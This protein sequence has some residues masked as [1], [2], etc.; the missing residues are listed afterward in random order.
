M[1]LLTS[2][3]ISVA[4]SS[5]VVCTFTFLLF[6]SGYT[7]QQ[8]T[9][10]SLQAALQTPVEDRIRIRPTKTPQYT[11]PE[12]DIA[13]VLTSFDIERDGSDSTEIILN[14]VNDQNDN[15]DETEDDLGL[16]FD[17]RLAYVLS[18]PEP[19]ALCSALLFAKHYR[20]L[21][22]LPSSQVSIIYLYPSEWETST[23]PTHIQTLRLLL[24][25]E[26]EYSVLLH[27]VPISR[28]WTGIDTESQLLSELARSAWPYDRVLYL[29]TPGLL[30][31]TARLDDALLTSYTVPSTLKSSWTRLKAASR[32]GSS[33]SLHP[34]VLLWSHGR[35][36]LE[37][38]VDMKRSLV[39]KASEISVNDRGDGA[40]I[41]HAA[42]VAFDWDEFGL[43]DDEGVDRNH[44]I[45]AKFE[46]DTQAICEGT[47]LLA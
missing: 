25:S 16:P 12:D 44:G 7:L 36:L 29:R 37:P 26:H 35:G 45:Y 43:G 13:E 5:G 14:T 21:T 39:V 18:L 4:I 40:S 8:Q 32:R 11:H 10:K 2:S 20:A 22:R 38:L 9:V 15:E 47:D 33:E 3:A 42:Y 34:E 41:D 23:N 28:V 30:T 1:V 6:L 27:P 17:L 46:R 24:H 19:A 31:N